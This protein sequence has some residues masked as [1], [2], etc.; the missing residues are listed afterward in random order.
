MHK[1]ALGGRESLF[2]SH[3]IYKKIVLLDFDYALQKVPMKLSE[4]KNIKKLSW[5]IERLPSY[6]HFVIR[7]FLIPAF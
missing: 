7:R 6:G 5:N 2:A 4:L 1:G 3:P